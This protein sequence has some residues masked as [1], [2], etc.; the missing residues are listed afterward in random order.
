MTLCLLLFS[1]LISAQTPKTT[2]LNVVLT[3]S[4]IGHY[5]ADLGGID[6]TAYVLWEDSG[7]YYFDNGVVEFKN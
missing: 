2:A 5:M 3:D 4:V 6:T 1:V 7:Y